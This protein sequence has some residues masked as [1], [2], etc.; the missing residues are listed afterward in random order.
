VTGGEP[1]AQK[2]FEDLL[3]SPLRVIL[4]ITPE[5]YIM[6]NS[7]LA[8]RHM[9]GD[10]SE[11]ELGKPQSADAERMNKYRKERGLEE[12]DPAKFDS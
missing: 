11:E 7:G 6:Y 8:N 5:K 4:A 3:D 10:V 12:R 2:A 9:R 1:Q